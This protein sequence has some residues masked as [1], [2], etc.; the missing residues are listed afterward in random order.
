MTNLFYE[1]MEYFTLVNKEEAEQCD[2]LVCVRSTAPA[3]FDDDEIGS[4]FACSHPV[5]FRP[6]APKAPKRLCTE[7]FAEMEGKEKH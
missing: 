7:C 3:Y 1:L 5:R 6:R 2:F 4:C